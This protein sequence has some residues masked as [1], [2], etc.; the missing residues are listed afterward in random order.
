MPFAQETG[1]RLALGRVRRRLDA[2]YGCERIGVERQLV[3][4]AERSQTGLP[5]PAAECGADVRGDRVDHLADLDSPTMDLVEVDPSHGRPA[6]H[7]PEGAQQLGPT[8]AESVARHVGIADRHHRD[9]TGREGCE[10]GGGGLGRLLGVVDDEQAQPGERAEGRGCRGVDRA[11]PHHRG[12][13]R[14]ELR[15]V[16]LGRPELLLHLGVLGEEVARREPLGT[17]GEAPEA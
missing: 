12:R 15:R 17:R 2:E 7:G 9:A 3:D 5:V 13:E 6:E 11:A 1:H 4:V 14:A 16:E 8:A 10:Q